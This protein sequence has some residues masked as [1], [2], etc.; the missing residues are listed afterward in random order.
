MLHAARASARAACI[1][2][3]LPL[4]D[5]LAERLAI[6]AEDPAADLPFLRAA[7]LRG[8]GFETE[9]AFADAHRR[10][11]CDA[12]G[13]YHARTLAE[14]RLAK[15]A[16]AFIASPWYLE[17]VRHGWGDAELFGWAGQGCSTKDALGLP[18]IAE[19]TFETA[20]LVPA[21][22]LSCPKGARLGALDDATATLVAD[23]GA[24]RVLYRF[25]RD[26]LPPFYEHRG[27]P[28]PSI[29]RGALAHV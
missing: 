17:A 13:R 11:L 10:R 9:A 1:A 15:V 20:G 2:S 8:Y 28:A 19:T 5:D 18:P 16:H 4:P 12:L 6:V 14:R 25:G 22:A 29:G 26:V 23:T 21:L 24:Q 27:A 7:L 3:R